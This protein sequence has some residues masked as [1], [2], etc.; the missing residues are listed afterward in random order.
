MS[1]LTVLNRASRIAFDRVIV[2]S[3]AAA[4][5]AAACA[6]S[7]PGSRGGD[8]TGPPGDMGRIPALPVPLAQ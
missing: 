1:F 6:A 4:Q 2:A 7:S 3:I 8:K 5:L